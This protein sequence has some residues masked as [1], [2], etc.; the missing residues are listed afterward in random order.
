M[1]SMSD[2]GVSGMCLCVLSQ[3]KPLHCN[4]Q[5]QTQGSV[6]NVLA[7]TNIFYFLMVSH[8]VSNQYIPGVIFFVRTHRLEGI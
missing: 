7:A 3:N 5:H 2:Q 8:F 6:I 1:T 4:S